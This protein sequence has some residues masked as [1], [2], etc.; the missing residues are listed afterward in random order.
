MHEV[1]QAI[2]V[3]KLFSWERLFEKRIGTVREQA[4]DAFRKKSAVWVAAHFVWFITPLIVTTVTFFLYIYVQNQTLTVPMIFTGLSLFTILRTPIDQISETLSSVV[5]SKV[6]L[7]R[8]QKFL[9]RDETE[10]YEVLTIC[11][12]RVGFENATLGWNRDE[13]SEFKLKGLNIN[14]RV[15]ELNVVA[16]PTGSGKTALLLGLLGELDL[17]DGKVYVPSLTPRDK[18]ETEHD[19][20]TDSVAYCSQNP[21]LPN[22][23]I[24]ENIVFNERYD[25]ARY[26]KVIEA[27]RLTRDFGIMDAG[28]QTE[29][30][31]KGVNL[32]GGQKQKISLARALYSS[33]RHV[34]LDDCLSTVDSHTAV[35][36]YEK[37]ILGPLMQG[38][39]CILA[40][41]NVGLTVKN[42]AWVVVVLKQGA[43]KCQNEPRRLAR[44]GML[45]N[46]VFQKTSLPTC[47]DVADVA[48]CTAV[49]APPT[50]Q[51]E[52]A[53]A[54][55]LGRAESPAW[56]DRGRRNKGRRGNQHQD[57]QVIYP[58]DG[59]LEAGV[60]I[61]A[62]FCYQRGHQHIPEVVAA[63]MGPQT[64][65]VD[66][67]SRARRR[68]QLQALCALLSVHLP[69]HRCSVL[70]HDQWP[71]AG[72]SFGRHRRVAHRVQLDT[73]NSASRKAKVF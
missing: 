35:R 45:E 65:R 14:F 64:Y 63:D 16:G 10:K 8:V 58:V 17:L 21:W 15:G 43:V 1:F 27:C 61:Y 69:A 67:R 54:R 48:E 3:V 6:S 51:E 56:Q 31:K 32:S 11:R 68:L 55:P 49:E 39:T 59:W 57:I 41:H 28:D 62:S 9:D 46:V 50:G 52:G 29:I 66:R 70:L 2:K 72:Q 23:T 25:A 24:K 33:S 73:A 22:S 18:L 4:L 37:C 7:D 53:P 19:G 13:S 34:L 40:S 12:N 60:H 42:A 30:G 71:A 20:L 5:Q 47:A 44:Q 36:I 26:N 38:R